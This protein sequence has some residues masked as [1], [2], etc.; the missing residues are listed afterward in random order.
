MT[1]LIPFPSIPR[2]GFLFPIPGLTSFYS[3]SLHIST[4]YSHFFIKVI[5]GHRLLLQL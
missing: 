2:G 4:G 3:R 5:Q 1:L